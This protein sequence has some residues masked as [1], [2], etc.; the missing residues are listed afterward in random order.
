MFTH[1]SVTYSFASNIYFHRVVYT[2][3]WFVALFG[4]Y[5]ATGVIDENGDVTEDNIVWVY[6]FLLLLA[7]FW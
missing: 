3:V 7:L 2:C 6:F 5:D 1:I 4:V